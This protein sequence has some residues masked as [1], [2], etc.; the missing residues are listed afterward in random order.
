MEGLMHVFE[1]SQNADIK[2]IGDGFVPATSTTAPHFFNDYGPRQDPK[3]PWSG[4]IRLF[5]EMVSN[6]RT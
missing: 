6:I 2:Q 5:L 3:N 1:D 4:D